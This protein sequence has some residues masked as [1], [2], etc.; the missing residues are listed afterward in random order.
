VA[1]KSAVIIV[2]S[3][4]HENVFFDCF[5]ISDVTELK[6]T[7]DKQE[8]RELLMRGCHCILLVADVQSG[9]G[10]VPLHVLDSAQVLQRAMQLKL[11]PDHL[12]FLKHMHDGLT[13]DEASGK[14]G[15]TPRG[16][17]DRLRAIY[18]KFDDHDNPLPPGRD[19]YRH[20][21]YFLVHGHFAVKR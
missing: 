14:V 21:I 1:D 9:S 8:V 2:R 4:K 11:R 7:L 10:I 15:L 17:N 3:K 5:S 12:S 19:R 16:G 20:V 13:V 18:E 6:N